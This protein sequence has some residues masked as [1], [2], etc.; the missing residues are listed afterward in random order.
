MILAMAMCRLDLTSLEEVHTTAAT[1]GINYLGLCL[2]CVSCQ[3]HGV[4]HSQDVS[5]S[6][7]LNSANF[8]LQL[9]L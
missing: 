2:D 6:H 4:G 3:E 8:S 5:V 7:E 9:M 1:L